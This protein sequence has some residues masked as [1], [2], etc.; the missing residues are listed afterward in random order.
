LAVLTY[1]GE[2]F[3]GWSDPSRL[4]PQDILDTVALYYLSASFPTSVL[5][6]NQV[7]MLGFISMTKINLIVSSGVQGLFRPKQI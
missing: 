6:Y 3:Y 4:D 7:W 1:I 2:K 5:M